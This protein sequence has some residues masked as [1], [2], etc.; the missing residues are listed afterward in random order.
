MN[1]NVLTLMCFTVLTEWGALL[2]LI[3]V[4]GQRTVGMGVMSACVMMSFIVKH[5]ATHYIA[6]HASNTALIGT[7]KYT[8]DLH[9]QN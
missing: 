2:V 9:A 4:M 7:F 3:Y 1:V 6:Y 8:L 5:M